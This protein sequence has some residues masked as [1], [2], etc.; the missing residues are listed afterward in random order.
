MRNLILV[1]MPYTMTGSN[2]VCMLAHHSPDLR[3]KVLN[4]YSILWLLFI[5][6]CA[7]FIMVSVQD[8]AFL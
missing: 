7:H 6:D 3:S 5:I 1:S 8:V 2:V 4:Q